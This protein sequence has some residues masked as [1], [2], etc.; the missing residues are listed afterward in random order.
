MKSKA[1]KTPPKRAPSNA[2]GRS[3]DRNALRTMA[4]DIDP[5]AAS[6]STG[7]RGERDADPSRPV[8]PRR[9]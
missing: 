5:G 2:K 8:R 9:G 3:A 6:F 7:A 4:R 1:S